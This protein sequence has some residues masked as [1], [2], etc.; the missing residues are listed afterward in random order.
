MRPATAARLGASR[1]RRTQKRSGDHARRVGAIQAGDVERGPV[2]RRRSRE[3]KAERHVHG[4]AERGDLDRRHAHVMVGR[5]H[6]I[7]LAAHR[8]H[9][10]RVGGERPVYS[11][12]ARRRREKL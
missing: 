9:E 12:G 4:T 10:N 5:D 2:I 1:N 7:E 6:R 8:A 3:R 11:R